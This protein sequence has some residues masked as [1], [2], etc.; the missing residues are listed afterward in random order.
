M[1]GWIS[2]KLK[3]A[4]NFLQQ[5]DQQAAESLRKGETLN[6]SLV[7]DE[8]EKLDDPRKKADVAPVKLQLPRKH[9]GGV[10]RPQDASNRPARASNSGDLSRLS[11]SSRSGPENFSIFKEEEDWTKLLS[12]TTSIKSGVSSPSTSIRSPR[13]F[14]RQT[15]PNRRSSAKPEREAEAVLATNGTTEIQAQPSSTLV[16]SDKVQLESGRS[17][18]IVDSESARDG[19]SVEKARA[20]DEKEVLESIVSS[21]DYGLMVKQAADSKGEEGF[22]RKEK[23]SD[24]NILSSASKL[25]RFA[26]IS[27]GSSDSGTESSSSSDS[28]Y[29][30]ERKAER[31]RRR[32]KILAERAAAMA[33]EAIKE[34]ENLVARL[35]GERDSLLKVVEERQKQQAQEASQ[36]QSSMMETM[37]AVEL[38]KQKHHSTRMEALARLAELETRNAEL[39]RSLATTQWDLQVKVDEVVDLREMIET[40]ELSQEAL[41]HRMSGVRLSPSSEREAKENEYERKVL[42]AE[43][44]FLCDKIGQ[45]REKVK[46]LERNIQ[47]STELAHPTEAEIE[48]KKRLVQLTDHL[49][50][51]Q[52]QVESLSSNKAT[53]QFRIETISRLVS[54]SGNEGEDGK[55]A[56]VVPA[57]A[58]PARVVDIEVGSGTTTVA[59]E[60]QMGSILRQVDGV[61]TVGAV[62]LR[63]NPTAKL[64]AWAYLVCLHLW[65]G[66]ILTASS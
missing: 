65:V 54:E 47:M 1:A 6:S 48:L 8:G 37:D 53:L 31:R 38:E 66:Y 20:L 43:Y 12:S 10:S 17:E 59:G 61:F 35:E 55:Q 3:S 63:K 56:L 42:E 18:E 27:N 30:S 57:A 28:E 50:Q 32:E 15:L 46:T 9:L 60:R 39:S 24:V 33:M 36:L 45:M 22:G 41:R 2:S 34:R 29:E 19:K 52:A 49:I 51:K 4:E 44:Q 23:K 5:I 25:P 64:F 62:F 14:K 40:K 11:S 7:L 26:S 16:N 13:N 58:V 21:L